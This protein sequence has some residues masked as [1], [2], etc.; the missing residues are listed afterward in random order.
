MTLSLLTPIRHTPERR[1]P[2]LR[3]GSSEQPLLVQFTMKDVWTC[4]IWYAR[5]RKSR[6]TWLLETAKTLFMI[7]WI[8]AIKIFSPYLNHV[9]SFYLTVSTNTWINRRVGAWPT[10]HAVV[11]EY[12]HAL[13]KRYSRCGNHCASGTLLNGINELNDMMIPSLEVFNSLSTVLLYR[14]EGAIVHQRN[15][16]FKLKEKI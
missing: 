10:T 16:V 3:S 8:E 14:W 1:D 7:M 4:L 9:P 5:G 15:S 13:V 12:G 11:A 2:R 6:Q